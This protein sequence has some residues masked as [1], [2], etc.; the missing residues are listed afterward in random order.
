MLKCSLLENRILAWFIEYFLPHVQN[1]TTHSSILAWRIS[2]TEE[3]GE[4]QSMGSQRLGHNWASNTHVQNCICNILYSVYLVVE[5]Q[6]R[7]YAHLLEKWRAYIFP[8]IQY[9]HFSDLEALLSLVSKWLRLHWSDSFFSLR[10]QNGNHPRM[11]IAL[12]FKRK[13]PC[14]APCWWLFWGPDR[15]F[16]DYA[17]LFTL[18]CGELLV[19]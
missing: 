11:L 1:W 17:N 8:C 5:W 15:V 19:Y 2:W 10:I 12:N 18:I 13:K 6:A 9:Y 3:P 4:L 7:W 16:C 14:Q